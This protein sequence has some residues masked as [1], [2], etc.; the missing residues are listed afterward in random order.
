MWF[1]DGYEIGADTPGLNYFVG[2][3]LIGELEVPGGFSSITTSAIVA[4]QAPDDGSL[5]LFCPSEEIS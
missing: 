3:A 1:R 2:D 4:P 5:T